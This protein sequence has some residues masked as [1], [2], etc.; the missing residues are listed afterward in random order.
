VEPSPTSQAP[1]SR[2]KTKTVTESLSKITLRAMLVV[3]FALLF[4][5]DECVCE[6]GVQHP[7]LQLCKAKTKETVWI[8]WTDDDKSFPLSYHCQKTMRRTSL[9]EVADSCP[10]TFPMRYAPRRRYLS[11]TPL[12]ALD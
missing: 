9:G 11:P 3:I 7:S 1:D 8:L 5:F 4:F 12:V 10:A 6:T 2:T